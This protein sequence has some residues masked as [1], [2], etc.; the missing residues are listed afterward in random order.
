MPAAYAGEPGNGLTTVICRVFESIAHSI[1]TPPNRWSIISL[2]PGKVLGEMKEEFSSRPLEFSRSIMP[3]M[4]PSN[5]SSGGTSS[6][7]FR[8]IRSIHR[9]RSRPY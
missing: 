9:D 6:K 3:S 5:K 2:N 7:E 8:W 4:A 1:P